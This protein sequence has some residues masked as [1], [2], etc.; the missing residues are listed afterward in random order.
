M[1]EYAIVSGE[2]LEALV[3]IVNQQ[4]ADG[5]QPEGGPF[6]VSKKLWAERAKTARGDL[7]AQALVR[8]T[9][10]GEVAE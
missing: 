4:I 2:T 3:G 8:E 5:W 1:N 10:N 9:E 6:V 7:V